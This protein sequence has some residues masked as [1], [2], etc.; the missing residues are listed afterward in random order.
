MKKLIKPVILIIAVVILINLA[1]YL[2]LG[3]KLGEL[4]GWIKGLG[5]LGPIV[6]LFIYAAATTAL[7]PGSAMTIMAGSIFGSAAGI[8]IVSAASTFGASLSF[9]IARY[10]ARNSV[11]EWLGENEKFK[12]LDELTEKHGAIIVAI[13]RLVPLFPF[14]LLNYGFGLTKVPFKIYVFWSWLCMLPGT[15]MYV[16]G[17]DVVSKTITSG[18][19]P[20]ILIGVFAFIVVLLAFLVKIAGRTLRIKEEKNI[21]REIKCF[22]SYDV[23]AEDLS[24]F[25]VDKLRNEIEK[26]GYAV[27]ALSG[28]GS[29]Q[30]VYR[31]L[32]QKAFLTGLSWDK[33]HLFWGDER[34]V[35]KD[36]KL[37][38]Y[39]MA[40]E[41]ILP[42][43]DI[44]DSN[45]HRIN[46]DLSSPEEAAAE[47]EKDL[48]KFFSDMEAEDTVFDVVL[49]GLGQDGHTASLFPAVKDN[50]SSTRLVKA[51]DAPDI[52]PKVKRVTMTLDLINKAAN[53]IFITGIT[54][55]EEAIRTVLKSDDPGCVPAGKVSAVKGKVYWYIVKK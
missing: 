22:H 21:T 53:I 10:F 8:I 12:S 55:K 19:V 43:I 17:S 16:V 42:V 15:V 39:R 46:T 9:L 20:W 41:I 29:P 5:M 47:Y 18:R 34:F 51:V 1:R 38:N 26:K 24:G 23:M 48:K 25:I 33:I 49:L 32:V 13:T 14:T 27:I 44:P 35:P 2:G 6:F 11:V 30:M 4:Q 50:S 31:A 3:E 40:Q 36:N 52:E 7:I 28:G 54:G 45:I 37:S